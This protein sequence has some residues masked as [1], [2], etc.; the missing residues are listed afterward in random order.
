MCA[1]CEDLCC[2]LKNRYGQDLYCNRRELAVEIQRV[3]GGNVV[4]GVLA[5]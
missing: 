3:I 4:E 5:R 1:I 2:E